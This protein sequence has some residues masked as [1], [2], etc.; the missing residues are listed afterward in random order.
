MH[1]QTDAVA[2]EFHRDIALVGIE[3][4]NHMRS[5]NS[6]Q[7]KKLYPNETNWKSDISPYHCDQ[8]EARRLEAQTTELRAEIRAQCPQ[9]R[10]D[11][12]DPEV[13]QTHSYSRNTYP[14]TKNIRDQVATI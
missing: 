1:K 3:I 12:H 2:A 9:H 6:S 5:S 8:H 10:I 4:S 14:N 13:V 7:C 11:H